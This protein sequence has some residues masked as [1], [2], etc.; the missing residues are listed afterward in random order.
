VHDLGADEEAPVDVE[1]EIRRHAGARAVGADDEPGAHGSAPRMRD[2]VGD[3]DVP[4]AQP[5]VCPR[6]SAA[7]R[8]CS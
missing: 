7:R 4:V 6:V 3:A 5:N 1:A 8:A 2:T